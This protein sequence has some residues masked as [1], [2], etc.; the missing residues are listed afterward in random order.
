MSFFRIKSLFVIPNVLFIEWLTPLSHHH[1]PRTVYDVHE[2]HNLH[3]VSEFSKCEMLPKDA[4]TIQKEELS[5]N[6]QPRE[7]KN[8][9]LYLKALFD[10]VGFIICNAFAHDCF[11]ISAVLKPIML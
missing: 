5:W 1:V 3:N 11:D 8:E 7:T 9:V 2:H 4:P 6:I 10:S